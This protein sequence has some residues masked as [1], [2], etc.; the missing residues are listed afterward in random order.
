[1][2]FDRGEIVAATATYGGALTAC[3]TAPAAYMSTES[4]ILLVFSGIGSMCALMGIIYTVWNGNRNFRLAREAA[5]LHR[6]ELS[7]GQK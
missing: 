4:W 3:S 1:M 6:L 7:H 2:V 5:E